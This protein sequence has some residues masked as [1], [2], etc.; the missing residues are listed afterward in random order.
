MQVNYSH[1][2]TDKLLP[3]KMSFN[4]DTTEKSHKPRQIK[5]LFSMGKKL[6]I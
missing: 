6:F 2:G 3:L 1:K 5:E 4:R